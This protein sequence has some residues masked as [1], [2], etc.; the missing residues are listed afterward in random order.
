MATIGEHGQ[1]SQCPPCKPLAEA[2]SSRSA[3][4]EAL[5]CLNPF[6]AATLASLPCS[7]QQLLHKPP[8]ELGE[9]APEVPQRSLKLFSCQAAWGEAV[10][11]VQAA[12]GSCHNCIARPEACS[13]RP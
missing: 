13:Y 11:G 6:S 9:L 7:L 2:P 5:P 3:F 12:G 4:L 10:R 8:D 1:R